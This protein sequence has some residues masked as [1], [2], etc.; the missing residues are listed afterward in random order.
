MSEAIKI[1]AVGVSLS[2]IFISIAVCKVIGAIIKHVKQQ[3]EER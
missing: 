1:I 3:E 2:L